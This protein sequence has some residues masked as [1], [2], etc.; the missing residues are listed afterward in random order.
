[1]ENPSARL[2]LISSSLVYGYGYLDHAETE[3]RSLLG[4]AGRVLFFPYALKKMD[5][6]TQRTKIRFHSMGYELESIHQAPDPQRAVENAEAVYM[7]GGNTFRLLHAL[8]RYGL[9]N[10]IRLRH[11]AGMPYIGSSAGS[12]VC[13]PTIR[14]TNDMPIVEPPSLASL[15]L[16]RFQINPHYTDADPKSTHMGETREERLVQYL[17]E[18]AT[19]VVGLREGCMLRVQNGS[20]VLKGFAGARIFRRGS[21]PVEVQ[22]D[23]DIVALIQ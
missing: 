8:Y 14:T 7:G 3:I 11:E 21:E 10:R 22:P 5:A 19:P 6:Y 18:N 23:T 17:E 4:N 1:M 20:L 16:I 9:V 12:V 13:C 15:N 2:L